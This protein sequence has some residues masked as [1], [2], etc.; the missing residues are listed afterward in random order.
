MRP[1]SDGPS[2]TVTA[3]PTR[4]HRTTGPSPRNPHSAARHTSASLRPSS[5]VHH[6][7]AAVAA[8]RLPFVWRR[9]G[10]GGRIS[11]ST[12][13]EVTMFRS[14]TLCALVFLAAAAFARPA[15][16]QTT[17]DIA[18]RV[19]DSSGSVLPGVTVTVT[20]GATAVPQTSITSDTG[21]FRFAGLV[22]G[23]YR[24]QFEMGGFKSTVLDNVRVFL[25]Q[26]TD[27]QQ[28][29]E[30]SAV[31]ETVTVSGGVPVV[32]SAAVKTGQTYTRE[33]LE[34]IPTARDPWVI[35]EQTPGV[36]MTQQNVGG[37]K[38]GQQSG[39]VVHG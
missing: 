11:A 16:A 30:L 18:G 8:C 23:L 28:R 31:Q 9:R 12:L 3:S 5:H 38:S 17:G 22:P 13:K 35:L 19:V 24:V 27:L 7:C 21:A 34:G 2:G 33:F 1:P 36:V 37:N 20:S 4:L 14:R 25:G 29:L 15:V 6:K 26:T 32:D 10:H 39:F